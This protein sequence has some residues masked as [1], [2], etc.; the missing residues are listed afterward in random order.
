MSTPPNRAR[1]VDRVLRGIC[2][3]CHAKPCLCEHKKAERE[4]KEHELIMNSL[5]RERYNF[6]VE[7]RG[8]TLTYEEWLDYLKNYDALGN[9]KGGD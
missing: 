3:E 5:L 1:E 9:Y 6:L 7:A 4:S 8:M 2:T